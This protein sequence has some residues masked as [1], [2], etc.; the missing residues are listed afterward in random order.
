MNEILSEVF[1]PDTVWSWILT[2]VGVTGF[3]FAGKK[4]WW[5]WYINIANQIFWLTY[6]IVTQQWGFLIGCAF[7]LWVF[8]GNAIEWTRDRHKMDMSEPIGQVFEMHDSDGGLMMKGELNEK[9]MK[10]FET[11]TNVEEA[12]SFYPNRPTGFCWQIVDGLLCGQESC[13]AVHMI[14]DGHDFLGEP[15]SY[16]G[17]TWEPQT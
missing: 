10:I 9:G 7:Y 15:P 16:V 2:L 3:Y 1:G 14:K 8:V 4:K 17:S 6:S 13:A 5:C 11:H 12:L